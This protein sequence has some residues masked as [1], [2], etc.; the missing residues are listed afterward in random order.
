M[1][2][3]R[4]LCS[5]GIRSNRLGEPVIMAG[6]KILLNL[7]G[8]H[9]KLESCGTHTTKNHP[10]DLRSTRKTGAFLSSERGTRLRAAHRKKMN[11]SKELHSLSS[12]VYGEGRGK[13]NYTIHQ[14][15]G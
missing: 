10:D 11:S 3:V 13:S 7:F 2:L 5:V 1:K 15:L 4:R 8:I 12:K 14:H 6:T 9:H